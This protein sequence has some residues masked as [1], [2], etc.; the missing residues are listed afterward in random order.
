MCIGRH[1]LP[2]LT[3]WAHV[4]GLESLATQA[5]SPAFH[6]VIPT[7]HPPNAFI[8]ETPLLPPP[9]SAETLPQ[10]H[11]P[12]TLHHF[13]EPDPRE[14]VRLEGVPDLLDSGVTFPLCEMK[15]F[16][17]CPSYIFPQPWS[18]TGA[19]HSR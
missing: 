1:L 3:F 5:F 12:S 15:G 18:M 9:A 10:A 17:R 6:P 11:L 16:T 19:A 2:A 8:A 7:L 4:A 13:W 14:V